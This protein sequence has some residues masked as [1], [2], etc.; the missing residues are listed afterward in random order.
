MAERSHLVRMH[1][2]NI[3]CIGNDGLQSN[4]TRLFVLLGL[5]MQVKQRLGSDE[6]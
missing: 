6:E 5:T 2:K 4:C 1:I 3:G